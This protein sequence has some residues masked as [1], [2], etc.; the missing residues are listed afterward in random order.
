MNRQTH[1]WK[2]V[3]RTEL[4]LKGRLRHELSA[5]EKAWLEDAVGRTLWLEPRQTL[6][7]RGDRVE[8]S[9]YIIEGVVLRS[10]D[11][12]SGQR[13]LVGLN[14]P[15]DFVDLHGFP[16]KRLDHSTSALGHVPVSYTHLTLP[17]KA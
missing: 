8:H 1:S 16:M 14:I 10:I 6:V 17:T 5:Q 15:G 12:R 7:Q 2:V 4:F 13:Q 9:Y 11:D 3:L